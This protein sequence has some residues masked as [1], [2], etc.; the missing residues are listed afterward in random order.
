MLSAYGR[1]LKNYYV[2]REKDIGVVISVRWCDCYVVRW[3]SDGSKSSNMD[4]RDI[5]YAKIKK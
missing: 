5:I 3:A 1:N 2:G 4:R